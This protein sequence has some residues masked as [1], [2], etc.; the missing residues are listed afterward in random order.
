[1]GSHYAWR[2]N[3]K[4]TMMLI[5]HLRINNY[6]SLAEVDI[7]LPSF[8]IL[9]GR[10]NAGKS[11][12]LSAVNLLLEG[13][14]RDLSMEDF[15][16]NIQGFEDEIV[17][18]AK[19]TGVQAFLPLCA[20]QHR[21]K[22]AACLEEDSIRIRRIATRNPLALGKLEIWQPSK[23]EFGTPTGLDSAFKQFLPEIIFIEAFK[24]PSIEAQSSKTTT[25]LSKILK[26]I[27]EQVSEKID[28]EIKQALAIAQKKFNIIEANGQSSDERPEE[29]KRIQQ[30]I[31]GHVQEIFTESEARLVFK[32]PDL[33]AM[34]STATV[35]L[36]D[37]QNGPW[38]SP[39]LKG[40]G[41][42]RMLYLALLEA[43]ADEL[44]H[45]NKEEEKPNRP[46]LLLFEEPEIFLHPSLQREIGDILEVISGSNQVVIV[47]HSPLLVTPQRIDNVLI[48]KQ[49]MIEQLGVRSHCIC[50]N[51]NA[52]P[53]PDDKQ[54]A[55]LLKFS[56]SSEFLF[57]DFVIVVE[58]PSDR[59]LIS[60]TWA[61]VKKE[62]SPDNNLTLAVVDADS[63]AVV[64]VWVRHLKAIGLETV[65]LVDLD[66]L[67]DGAGK[68]LKDDQGL[69]QL[70]SCFW[71]ICDEKNFGEE[72]NGKKIVSASKKKDAFSIFLS[73][74]QPQTVQ[75]RNALQKQDIWV[76]LGGEI[77]DYF[78]LTQ[79]S[80]GQYTAI[81]QKIM[82]GYLEIP[83]E[84]RQ[85]MAWSIR[86]REQTDVGNDRQ[87]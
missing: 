45:V 15:H 52:L 66:F 81:S 56:N 39:G 7:H 57:A 24:D 28:V 83:D 69:S 11:N 43:L 65:G 5:N 2:E 30:R 49:Q 55:A 37:H 76:L 78:G 6:R 42:Q 38:T 32:L 3:G 50:P 60:A 61:K 67:W 27:V 31:N 54:L 29:L 20:E 48:V 35:E 64:P 51:A 71:K 58:G 9:V 10:N 47:T 59:A 82:A 40:Q 63:K 17:I 62:I 25:I 80:K 34:M 36:R 41:F 44:R 13:S 70:M 74:L 75:V 33:D 73:E 18:E 46:F 21:P 85:L 22:I 12:I 53:D 23:G 4:P 77:E 1:M 87:L 79:N 84:I 72:K 26:Q 86:S 14:S 8:L 16:H 68:C 19:V